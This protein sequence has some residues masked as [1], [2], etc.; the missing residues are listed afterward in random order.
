MKL[1]ECNPYVRAAMIQPA[2]LEG[3]AP[4]LAYDHR[5]FL[6]LDGEGIIFLGDE[7]V[8]IAPR[9]LIFLPP[10]TEYYFSGRMKVVVLNFDMTRACRHRTAP[11]TPVGREVFDKSLKFDSVTADGLEKRVVLTVNSEFIDDAI[12]LVRVFQSKADESDAITSALLKALAAEILSRLREGDKPRN[13]AVERVLFFI[14]N[15]AAEIDGNE[16]LAKKFGYH[17]VYIASMVK[18]ATGKSLHRVILESRV[19]LAKRYLLSTENSVEQIA[20]DLGFSSRNH[21]CTVFRQI[22][23]VSPLTYKKQ[24]Q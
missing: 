13:E 4:R 19:A 5:L 21:F 18:Q 11:L 20:Y 7:E 17:P 1:S 2:I 23:G 24:R 22:E 3:D 14:R 16:M 15:N 12:E 6:I 9:S 10:E 8:K